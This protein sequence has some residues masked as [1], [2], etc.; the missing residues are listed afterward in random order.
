MQG[1]M[2]SSS[3]AILAAFRRKGRPRSG[4]VESSWLLQELEVEEEL[5]LCFCLVQTQRKGRRAGSPFVSAE[6]AVPLL[7]FF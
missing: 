7:R 2:T 1:S 6:V 4:G 5:D 3:F